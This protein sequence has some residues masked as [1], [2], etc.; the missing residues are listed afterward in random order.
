MTPTEA[1]NSLV[2]VVKRVDVKKEL[3]PGKTGGVFFMDFFGKVPSWAYLPAASLSHCEKI[4]YFSEDSSLL[5]E[6]SLF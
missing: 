2:G 3:L 1:N 4:Y 5:K 6:N